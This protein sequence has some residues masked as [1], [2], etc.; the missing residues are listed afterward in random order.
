[1]KKVIVV[2][3]GVLDEK[4]LGELENNG[5]IV[6]ICDEPEKVK[7]LSPEAIETSDAFLAALA[8]L[9]QTFDIGGTI[10]AKPAY[11]FVKELYKM[12]SKK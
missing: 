8:G 11:E 4:H 9:T 12:L 10:N 6:I 3:L 2:P 1:M 5:Y 7:I